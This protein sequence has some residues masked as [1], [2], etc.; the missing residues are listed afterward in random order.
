MFLIDYHSTVKQIKAKRIFFKVSLPFRLLFAGPF[1]C[2][3][4][5]MLLQKMLLLN[6][7]MKSWHGKINNKNLIKSAHNCILKLD[8]IQSHSKKPHRISISI[9]VL[10]NIC[11]NSHYDIH[12]DLCIYSLSYQ[13]HW[14]L[15]SCSMPC[16]TAEF[17]M[18]LQSWTMCLSNSRF[19]LA[20]LTSVHPVKA[21]SSRYMT[22]LVNLLILLAWK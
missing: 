7:C 6:S 9:E 12:S 4:S 13:Q 19:D 1:V 15:I 5:I 16:P 11:Q 10:L 14:K 20:L 3:V 8:P 22:R 21:N 17:V 2:A 18:G